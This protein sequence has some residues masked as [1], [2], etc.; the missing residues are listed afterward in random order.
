VFKRQ[1][2]FVAS[3]LQQMEGELARRDAELDAAGLRAA[4]SSAKLEDLKMQVDRWGAGAVCGCG[5]MGEGR[6][7]RHSWKHV[8][9]QTSKY[10]KLIGAH[11]GAR[12]MAGVH[13]ATW[14]VPAGSKS[15]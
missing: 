13:W 7:G 15:H 2:D 12:D 11:S 6:G 4:D 14:A 9:V 1:Y 8:L 3:K 5:C 10:C